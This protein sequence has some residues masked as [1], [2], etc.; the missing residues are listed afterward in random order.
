MNQQI[1]HTTIQQI[2]QKLISG[3]IRN[4]MIHGHVSFVAFVIGPDLSLTPILLERVNAEQKE[5]LG[6]LLKCI[7]PHVGAIAIISETWY[8]EATD[9]T[10]GIRPSEHKDRKESILVSVSSPHG[11]PVSNIPFDRNLAG[12]PIEPKEITAQ[13]VSLPSVSMNL[14][15]FYNA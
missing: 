12:H 11:D 6:R 2:G 13:W 4:L 5:A 9:P 14:G 1:S 8:V 10:D 15:G 7:A 3:A